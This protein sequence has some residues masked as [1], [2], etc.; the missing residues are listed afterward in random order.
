VPRHHDDSAKACRRSC[1]GPLKLDS[2][3]WVSEMPTPLQHILGVIPWRYVCYFAAILIILQQLQQASNV[4]ECLQRKGSIYTSYRN[5]IRPSTEHQVISQPARKE[6]YLA[7]CLFIKDES[8]YL[9]EWLDHHYHHMNVSHFYIMDDASNPPISTVPKFGT[10]PRS[11]LTFHLYHDDKLR[12]RLPQ[13]PAMYDDCVSIYGTQHKWMGFIDVDEFL[14]VRTTE[15]LE[16]ILRELETHDDIGALAVNSRLH[17]SA[18][19]LTQPPSAR[20]SFN[21]CVDGDQGDEIGAR[22]VKSIVRTE[23]YDWAGV[24]GVHTFQLRNGTV[25]VGEDWVPLNATKMGSTSW[26]VPVSWNRVALHHYFLKSK[27][28]YERKMMGAVGDN[29]RTW[30]FWERWEGEGKVG[31]GEMGRYDP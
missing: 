28:E 10:V 30:E 1:H 16:N 3:P 13:Q 26:R 31:C 23:Y 29:P 25:M 19:L 22:Y 7:L 4:D 17:T 11:A 20:K 5:F 12:K 27:G 18:G 9:P 6:E 14:E 2:G 21:V 8:Q 15:T 24:D